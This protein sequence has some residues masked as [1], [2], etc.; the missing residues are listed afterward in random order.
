MSNAEVSLKGCIKVSGE[1]ATV[2]AIV[3]VTNHRSAHSPTLLMEENSAKNRG[4]YKLCALE[5]ITGATTR[6]TNHRSIHF[7]SLLLCLMI[8]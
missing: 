2:G 6:V 1:P 5:A 3:E 8:N 4:P 7:I